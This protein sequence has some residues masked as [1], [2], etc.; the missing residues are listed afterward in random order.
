M[1]SFSNEPTPDQAAEMSIRTDFL[2]VIPYV[3]ALARC[4]CRDDAEAATLAR[5]SV[6]VSLSS[7]GDRVATISLLNWCFANE[8]KVLHER[9]QGALVDRQRTALRPSFLDSL[10]RRLSVPAAKLHLSEALSMLPNEE[11]EAVVLVD[12]ARRTADEAAAICKCTANDLNSRLNRG[13]RK[14]DR[15]LAVEHAAA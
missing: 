8:L 3:R 1:I 5:E 7:H 9:T 13:R 2:V 14:L 4:L 6:K 15:M 12:G 10:K 11:R